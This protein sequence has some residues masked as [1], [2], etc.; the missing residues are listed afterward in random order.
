MD[1]VFPSLDCLVENIARRLL[2][3]AASSR[4]QGSFDFFRLRLTP[5][6]MTAEGRG[7][8]RVAGATF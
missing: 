8:R 7:G 1:A 2:E 5:L 4:T 3:I 6:K